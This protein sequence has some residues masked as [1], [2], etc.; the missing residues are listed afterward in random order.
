MSK[1]AE[2]LE[3]LRKSGM[4]ARESARFDVSEQMYK[5]MQRRKVSKAEMAHRLGTS[6]SYVTQMLQGNGNFTIDKMAEIAHAL[7]CE[8][9]IS[10][11]EPKKK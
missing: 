3:E 5:K 9:R 1:F 2:M 8:L 6:R 10:F 11:V 4:Y 7:G